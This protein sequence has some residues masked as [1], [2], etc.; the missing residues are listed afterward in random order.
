MSWLAITIIRTKQKGFFFS[1]HWGMR[2]LT[3]VG[4]WIENILSFGNIISNDTT[5]AILLPSIRNNEGAE[6]GGCCCNQ[7]QWR[8]WDNVI[9]RLGGGDFGQC[10][11][12]IKSHEASLLI[13]KSRSRMRE[14]EVSSWELKARFTT[15]LPF[16]FDQ[17]KVTPLIATLNYIHSSKTMLGIGKI[18]FCLLTEFYC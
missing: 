5:G 9:I 18:V 4:V 2:L 11:E 17:Q 1:R 13:C 15:F 6:W 7:W 8:G 3:N 12:V 14:R 10:D 16:N